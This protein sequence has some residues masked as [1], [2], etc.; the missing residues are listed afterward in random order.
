MNQKNI[1]FAASSA[2]GNKVYYT[3]EE[4]DLI[5]KFCKDILDTAEGFTEQETKDFYIHEWLQD[6]ARKLNK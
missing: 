6:E 1:N 3:D 4:Q 2:S 5:S